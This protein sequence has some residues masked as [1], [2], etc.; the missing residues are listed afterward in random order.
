MAT[1]AGISGLIPS[2]YQAVFEYSRERLFMP[3]A[4]SVLTDQ[5]GFNARQFTEY[6]SAGTVFAN[7]A[8]ATDLPAQTFN[9]AAIGT[10]TPREVGYRI[11]MYDRRTLTD[12]EYAID[13]AADIA[14]ELTFKIVHSIDGFLPPLKLA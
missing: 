14:R 1:Y 3:S 6:S 13:T 11:D 10:L 12:S 9:P 2:I 4:V 8:E 7:I 5:E